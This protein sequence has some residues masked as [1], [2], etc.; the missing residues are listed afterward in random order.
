MR[1]LIDPSTM[2]LE[3]KL[4]TIE[5]LWSDIANKGNYTSPKWHFEELALREEATKQGVNPTLNWNDVK[6]E[7]HSGL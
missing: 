5:L 3:E 2:T 1:T 4:E 6:R 7:L